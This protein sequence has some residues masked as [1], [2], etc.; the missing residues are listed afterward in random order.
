MEAAREA[1]EE[2]GAVV[3]VEAVKVAEAWVAAINLAPVPPGTVFA[4]I[5]DIKNRTR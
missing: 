5:A 3:R 1:V 2:E 4:Q